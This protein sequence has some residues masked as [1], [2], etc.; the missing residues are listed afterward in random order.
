MLLS[1]I[2]AR[3]PRQV[4]CLRNPPK[5]IIENILR[6]LL[7]FLGW[8]GFGLHGS[9]RTVPK[10]PR[11]ARDR[12]GMAPRAND[13]QGRPQDSPKNHQD[14]PKMIPRR[15]KKAQDSP[16]TTQECPKKAPGRPRTSQDS[17]KTAQDDRKAGSGRPRI[18]PRRS[19]DGPKTS[20]RR[21]RAALGTS[22]DGQSALKPSLKLSPPGLPKLLTC[23]PEAS[24][25]R[26]K[27]PTP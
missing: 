6:Y 15:P 11:T 12:L 13:P 18:A 16:R 27:P 9:P 3:L 14:K 17:S 20:P 1:K 4:P 10:R 25:S 5:R 22:R 8:A 19:Q 26:P 7:S 23:F 24:H 2:L 21:L